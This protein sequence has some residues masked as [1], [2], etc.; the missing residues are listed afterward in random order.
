MALVL[1]IVNNATS[2]C[3]FLKWKVLI[4]RFL[5][6]FETIALALIIVNGETILACSFLK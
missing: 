5:T 1:I 4:D 2:A 6:V 3:S